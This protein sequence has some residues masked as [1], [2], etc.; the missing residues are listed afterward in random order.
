MQP[1]WL[2]VLPPSFQIP[3]STETSTM[4]NL[5]GSH[6]EANE[7]FKLFKVNSVADVKPSPLPQLVTGRVAPASSNLTSPVR[8]VGCVFYHVEGQTGAIKDGREEFTKAFEESQ[9]VD[10]VLADPAHTDFCCAVHGRGQNTT[11]R[12]HGVANGTY[13]QLGNRLDALWVRDMSS[14]N[15]ATLNACAGRHKVDLAAAKRSRFFEYTFDV[16]EQIVMLGIVSE[17][18]GPDGACTTRRLPT[19]RRPH[20]RVLM[21]SPPPPPPFLHPLLQAR[22]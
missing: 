18:V 7:V 9:C 8:G 4:G 19:A 2:P 5:C 11:V 21:S 6:E 13:T 3:L 20:H 22:R 1:L 10:F 15:A 14:A 16:N 12:V 17:R